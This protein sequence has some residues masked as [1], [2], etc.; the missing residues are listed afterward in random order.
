MKNADWDPP[1]W[2]SRETLVGLRPDINFAIPGAISEQYPHA[3]R[4][5]D[6][7]VAEFRARK[8]TKPA[9]YIFTYFH[10]EGGH[11]DRWYFQRPIDDPNSEYLW[12]IHA[13]LE[14]RIRSLPALELPASDV[15]TSPQAKGIPGAEPTTPSRTGFASTAL[16][17]N[18]S[19]RAREVPDLQEP[20]SG[21][22]TAEDN[23]AL[24]API[25][26]SVAAE[27]ADGA[28]SGDR[29]ERQA[30]AELR[31]IR[32]T[33]L[34]RMLKTLHDHRCQIC[35]E[36]LETPKGPYAEGAHLRPL[37]EP[38]SGPDQ[39]DNLL[40]LCPNDHVRLDRG[41]LHVTDD[42]R[43]VITGTG[44]VAGRLRQVDGH[45]LGVG[46]VRYHREHIAQPS[47]TQ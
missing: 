46:H 39:L 29:V 1:R 38:H 20:T 13:A 26:P 7:G 36:R 9:T 33:Q 47:S 18:Q 32:D 34:T 42:L 40:C 2:V 30:T 21:P 24:T 19:S 10:P 14:N 44:A 27:E 8:K 22:G 3:P 28:W 41:A 11:T 23:S 43:V 37:G 31:L 45:R 12:E 35:G 4:T 15:E 5:P 17:T 16:H 25:D 6:R